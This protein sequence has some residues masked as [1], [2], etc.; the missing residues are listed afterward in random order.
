MPA[1]KGAPKVKR[2][3]IH[4]VNAY[5]TSETERLNNKRLVRAHVGQWIS[6]QTKGRIV[7]AA[8]GPA[9]LVEPPL[10]ASDDRPHPPVE[11]VDA[12]SDDPYLSSTSPSSTFTSGSSPSSHDSPGSSTSSASRDVTPIFPKAPHPRLPLV[13][14]PSQTGTPSPA[15]AYSYQQQVDDEDERSFADWAESGTSSSRG[16]IEI[17]GAGSLD[18]FR[19][20]PTNIDPKLIRLSDEYC[21]SCL[22][23]GLTPGPSGTNMQ[24]WFPLG[25]S[26]PVLFTAFLFGSLSH[27]RVQALKGWIP[28]HIFR[29]RQQRLLEH[30]EMETV[31]LVSREMSNPSRAVCDAM[32]WSVVCMAHN[33]A[34][35]DVNGLPDI[36]FTAPMQ[37]LQ[38]LDVYGCL[39]PNLIH[40]GG[41]IQMVN[42][43]G[44]IEKIELPGL[45]SVIS[46]SDIVTSS[47]FLLHPVFP[48]IPLEMSRKN[49]TMQELLGYR[50]ADIDRYYVQHQHLGLSRSIA[51]ILCAMNTYTNLVDQAQRG[52]YDLSLL[53][54]QRS[55]V[56]YT[57]LCLPPAA[58][59]QTDPNSNISQA[60]PLQPQ[61]IIYEALRLACLIYSVGI[62]LPIPPQ[63]SPI[64]NLAELLRNVLSNPNHPSLWTTPQAQVALLWILTLGGIAATHTPHRSW[65]IERLCRVVEHHK[66]ASYE[67]LSR[68]LAMLAWYP[69]ACD[70]PGMELWFALERARMYR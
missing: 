46:F 67:H 27:M 9:S 2:D 41:L 53:A 43:R 20:Y 29:H 61:D 40:I 10:A 49:K 65:Y 44:G 8:A 59:H 64:M 28:R 51:E 7:A 4:F 3:T 15:N 14:I 25:V 26:D 32:I 16:Y 22:W 6:T 34:E 19:A 52:H 23:P 45:A 62:V 68:Y 17:V 56:H 47:T 13:I 24:S 58:P 1:D 30:A 66:I 57:L 12:D 48:W 38:W 33:K 50:D 54:D 36:P 35:D 42:L 37:R 39:R 11:A 31:R 69:V 5:P 70:T 21:I 18:P 63:S 60:P 55:I